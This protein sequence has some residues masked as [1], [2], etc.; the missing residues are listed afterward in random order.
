MTIPSPLRVF[1]NQSTGAQRYS[2]SPKE[3]KSRGELTST[4]S[5]DWQRFIEIQFSGAGISQSGT[6]RVFC[7]GATAGWFLAWPNLWGSHRE[8]MMDMENLGPDSRQIPALSLTRDTRY[9]ALLPAG[10]V[11]VGLRIDM[12]WRGYAD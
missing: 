12:A 9:D 6:Q 11:L 8:P 3:G 2:G 10:A 7:T 5:P 1:L 4:M